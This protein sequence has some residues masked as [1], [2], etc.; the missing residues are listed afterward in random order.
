MATAHLTSTEPRSL[1]RDGGFRRLFAAAIGSTLGTEISH[2]A[3]PLLAVMALHA[4]AGQVGLLATLSTLP[5]LL[6]GLPA[7]A[8][9]DRVRRRGVMIAADLA[10]GLLM[11]SLPVAWWLGRLTIEQL[12]LTVLLAGAAT[13]FFDVASL[14]YLPHLVTRRRVQEGNSAL[15]SVYAGGSV[16]GNSA[17][18]FLVQLLT[19][20]AT[21]A[22]DAVSYLWSAA[23]LAGI[24]RPEPRP[25]ANGDARLARDIRDGL[26][27][28]LEHPLLRSIA[29]KGA[30]TNLAIQVTVTMLPVLF[31][32]ELGLPA[33]ILGAYLAVGGVGTFLGARASGRIGRRLGQGRTPWILGLVMAPLVFLVPLIEPGPWLW[34]AMGA[35]LAVTFGVGVDNVVLVSFRQRCTPDRLLGRMNATMRF[36]LTGALAVGAGLG[37]LVGQL[38]SVRAALWVGAA[39]LAVSWLPLF[40]SPM[41]TMRDFPG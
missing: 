34:A 28:V 41:R 5:F 29:V 13:V 26:T 35:W 24:R 36:L 11:A 30:L 19:A 15:V 1:L 14:S 10:R 21:V 31:V 27:F 17:G 2:V 3:L 12:Y 20:P 25:E 32:G 7:G 33:G 8:W 40:F 18:G 22:V 37:G 38:V 9:V 39:V 4:T 16:A 23:C 6:I